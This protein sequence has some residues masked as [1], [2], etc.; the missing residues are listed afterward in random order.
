MKKKVKTEVTGTVRWS[1]TLELVKDVEVALI[2]SDETNSSSYFKNAKQCCAKTSERGQFSFKP[3]DI[4]K[5]KEVGNFKM[6]LKANGQIL[7]ISSKRSFKTR[8][9]SRGL[10]ILIP[11]NLRPREK[12]EIPKI[13][14]GDLNL[15]SEAVEKAKPEDVIRI[16]HALVDPSAAKKDAKKIAELSDEL[17]PQHG[18]KVW[19]CE[20][21]ILNT[22]MEL[23]IKKRWP[24]EV[25]LAVE[26]IL[27]MRGTDF[28]EQTLECPNFIITYQDSGTAAVPSSTDAEDV[29]D[30]GSN[31]PV[32]LATLPAG[33]AP[34][35]IKRICFWLER[36]LSGYI[37]A[38]FSMLNPAASGKIPVVVNTSP[39]G[40][41]SSSG[42]FYLNNNL[43]P[44]VLC[45]VA[46]HE[47]FHMVQY[48]YGGSGTWR[49]SVFEGGAVFAEDTAADLMNRYI[50]EAR[51]NF[52][53]TGV[54]ADPNKSLDT[55]RYKC[56]LF[57][58]YVS[59]QH[60]PDQTEP[61]VGVETYRKIIEKCSAGSYA[62]ADVRAAIRELPW[63]QDF[64][65]FHYLD[66]AKQDRTN[67]ETTFGNYA[68]ACY[69][70]DLGINQPD[71]RFDFIE[72]EENIHI[73]NVIGGPPA[74]ITSMPSVTIT[75]TV[76]LINSGAGSSQSFV[77][78]VNDLAS[79][80]YVVNVDQAVTNVEIEFSANS[81]FTSLLFQIAQIDEDG[82]LR[83]IHRSDSSSYTKRITNEQD[84]KKLD[85]LLIVVSGC[86]TSG[87]FTI[88]VDAVDAAPD[89]M[90]TRWHSMMK[91]EYEIDSRNWAWTWVSP[92]IWVDNDNNGVADSEVFFNFNNKLNI[93]MHNKGNA[94]ANN[95]QVQFYYQSAAGG[96]S[97]AAWLPVRNKDGDV[98]ILMGLSLASDTS[99]KWSVDWSPTPDGSSHHFCIRAIITAPGDPNGDNKRVLSNFGNIKSQFPYFDLRILRRNI[100][101]YHSPIQ[102]KVIPRLPG[103]YTISRVDLNRQQQF[104][105]EPGETHLD[106]IRINKAKTT[107]QLVNKD[108]FIE[109][110]YQ[111]GVINRRLDI[112]PNLQGEYK[113][114]A[115]AL[116]PGVAGRPMVT[117]VHE[118]NG[119]A[120]GGMTF[121]LSDENE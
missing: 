40:S 102:L 98:Q 13:K 63:Y 52:N 68:L 62:T 31:P 26:D 24:R 86:E 60:S 65:Q 2:P 88:D 76:N 57:W 113:T 71:R 116:P 37:N 1:D 11:G 108:P 54:L 53:G 94:N 69:L 7:H 46:V 29:I 103:N 23:I 61:F 36:A 9:L 109:K 85:R 78:N 17:I 5:V 20:T 3:A 10:D 16:A 111:Q 14:V 35:Y 104:D 79:R 67:S 114:P 73:D 48:E 44:D 77:A 8:K 89:V 74:D 47:L 100:L 21:P 95:I 27:H 19:R 30:P 97:D 18:S 106:E 55:S 80:Y 75:T 28:A 39:Y 15:N 115:E 84:G 58:R 91:K 112:K 34:T 118:V 6:L 41:A 33:G 59:E 87:S 120:L 90:V 4:D 82:N 66:A 81:G 99:N 101:E 43:D 45:A 96:L 107:K 117:V 110:L 22:I 12:Q 64:Y 56:S 70:K 92:D 72:D 38:P 25:A 49:S 42:T 105:L 119:L 51:T 83:D 93:R 32:V 50:D 121:L